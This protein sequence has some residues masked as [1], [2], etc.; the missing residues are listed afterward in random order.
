MTNRWVSAEAV[1]WGRA[2]TEAADAKADRTD[3]RLVAV[4]V[5]AGEARTTCAPS[6]AMTELD[7][8]S[9]LKKWHVFLWLAIVAMAVVLAAG[10]AHRGWLAAEPG[11]G[12]HAYGTLILLVLALSCEFMDATI[13]M[14]YGT[15]LTPVLLI[16]GYPATAVVQAALLSQFL[17]NIAATFFHHQAGN[18]DFWR[19]SQTR[20]AG[21]LMGGIGLAVSVAVTLFVRFSVP[22]HYIRPAVTIMLMCIGVF[23]IVAPR[24]KVRFRMR[25]VGILAAIAAFNKAF[26]GGGY[27]PLVCGGQVLVGLPVRAAVASTAMAE[28]IVCLAAVVTFYLSGQSIPLHLLVPLTAGAVLSTPASAVT[29]RRLPAGVVKKVMAVAIILLAAYALYKG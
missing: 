24:L 10:D 22:R 23:M 9:P 7:P 21:L 3:V 26:S 14:G 5:A 19:D 6:S 8:P 4:D 27:G 1:E 2:E 15:T 16:L 17:A 13:G 25:N 12:V 18:F 29:L 28:A 11:A 20:N